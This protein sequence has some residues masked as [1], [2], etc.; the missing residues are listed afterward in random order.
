M[1]KWT[2]AY[3][4]PDR[5][6]L[7]TALKLPGAGPSHLHINLACGHVREWAWEDVPETSVQCR[8]GELDY[9]HWFIQYGKAEEPK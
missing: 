3:Y 7:I 9:E 6:T 1:N 4:A 5:E 8:C 2:T